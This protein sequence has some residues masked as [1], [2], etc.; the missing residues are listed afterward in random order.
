MTTVLFLKWTVKI[1]GREVIRLTIHNSMFRFERDR[2][3]LP[4]VAMRKIVYTLDARMIA[5]EI[6]A[7]AG[8]VRRV[9]SIINLL[10]TGI[11]LC[12]TEIS[13]YVYVCT[14]V[15]TSTSRRKKT[16][17]AQNFSDGFP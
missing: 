8:T 14:Y 1:V 5:K 17:K 7:A 4:R 16:N 2:K 13:T 11:A 9:E 6:D 3:I 15:H 12:R 10:G